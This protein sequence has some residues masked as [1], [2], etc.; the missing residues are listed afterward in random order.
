MKRTLIIFF[1]SVFMLQAQ[2]IQPYE[3]HVS[4]DYTGSENG[5]FLA[6]FSMDTSGA[7]AVIIP[8]GDTTYTVITALQPDLTDSTV[9]AFMMVMVDTAYPLEPQTWTMGLPIGDPPPGSFCMFMTN[10]DSSLLAEMFEPFMDSTLVDELS[11][12]LLMEIVLTLASYAYGSLAGSVTVDAVSPDT[13]NGTFSSTVVKV[14]FPPPTI[15][16]SNGA[17]HMSGI[18][19]DLVSIE[20]GD[21]QVP[22][23]FDLS[24]YPNPFNPTTQIRFGLHTHDRMILDIVDIAGRSVE[25]L[26]QGYFPSGLYTV[27][28]DARQHA[29]G[30]YFIRLRSGHKTQ[31]AK[32]LYLK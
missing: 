7:G 31:T 3:G 11:D 4:F 27:S 25:T 28:W 22:Q 5:S 19:I 2:E 24:A 10:I 30:I 14:G 26:K 18:N 21:P 9:D 23:T 1:Y 8:S 15:Q 17:F 32:I 6:D 29:S 20:N 12:S 13:L 16:I